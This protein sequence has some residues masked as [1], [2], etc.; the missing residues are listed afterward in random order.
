MMAGMRE[1]VR[2]QEWE[3]RGELYIWMTRK[4]EKR[5]LRHGGL[6]VKNSDM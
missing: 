2:Y 4:L 6:E 3:E 1:I 5:Y